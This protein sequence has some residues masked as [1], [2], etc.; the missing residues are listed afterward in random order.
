MSLSRRIQEVLMMP[1]WIDIQGHIDEQIREH[2]EFLDTQMQSYPDTLTGKKA[3]AV[4]NRMR[5]LSELK[6]WIS[7]EARK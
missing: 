4:S 3:I 5:A 7:D 1:G 6:E 2:R